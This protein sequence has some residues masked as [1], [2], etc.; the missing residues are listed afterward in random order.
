[1][2]GEASIGQ[3]L[4]R[5]LRREGGTVTE[6]LERRAGEAILAEVVSQEKRRAGPDNALALAAGAPVVRRAVLLR[7]RSTGRKFVY[8]ESTIASGRLPGSVMARLWGGR[9]PIGRVLLEHGLSVR[10]EAVGHAPALESAAPGIE[11]LLQ[12]LVLSHRQR[13]LVGGVPV[14]DV[15]EWFLEPASHNVVGDDQGTG[16]SGSTISRPGPKRVGT[17]TPVAANPTRS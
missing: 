3:E 1:M 13:V 2:T 17:S 16:S 12:G 11:P 6:F 7:G 4:A 15:S 10:R 14:I 9:E 5:H 8:A